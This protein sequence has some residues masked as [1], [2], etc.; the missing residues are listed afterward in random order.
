[1]GDDRLGPDLGIIGLTA[2]LSTTPYLADFKPLM[3][4][5]MFDLFDF[6]SSNILLPVG[7]IF[8]CLFVGW[9]LGKRAILDEA[10]NGGLIGNRRLL[11]VYTFIVQYLTPIAITIVLL[12]GLGLIKL[13]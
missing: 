13:G 9:R 8:I 2:T 7:G 11:T 3:G 12:S 1:M 4:K 5:T 6:A 10:S